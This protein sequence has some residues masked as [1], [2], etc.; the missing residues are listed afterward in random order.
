MPSP[1]IVWQGKPGEVYVNDTDRFKYQMVCDLV[2]TC[3]T[4]LQ[5]HLAISNW[6]PIPFHRNCR[7]HQVPIKPGQSASPYR[8]FRE[9]LDGLSDAQ[10]AEAIGA[11]NY[12]LLK[13]GVVTWDDIVT[14]TRVRTLKEVVA[15]KKLTV[16]E[17]V[18]SGVD[19][20]LAQAAYA[21]VHT[22][23]QEI[24]RQHRQELVQRLE[25]A[26][27]DRKQ[28]ADVIAYDIAKDAVAIPGQDTP[29]PPPPK[30]DATEKKALTRL[31]EI[32]LGFFSRKKS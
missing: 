5:Y 32:I 30:L 21:E 23:E 1:R 13:D 31:K 26:G 24:I 11:S 25:T 17:M 14:P 2:N 27:F 6:W 28:I 10:K 4:C 22:P 19:K 7:C 8:D 20:R 16:D 9:V 18:A 12:K 15:A 3:G 29:P